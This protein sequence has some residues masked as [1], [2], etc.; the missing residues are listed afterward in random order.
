MS[1]LL[2]IWTVY[3]PIKGICMSIISTLHYPPGKRLIAISL[4]SQDIFNIFMVGFFLVITSLMYEGFKLK[5]DQ[6]LT[7]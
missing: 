2:F 1:V 6:D 7:V 4:S 5:C 3:A